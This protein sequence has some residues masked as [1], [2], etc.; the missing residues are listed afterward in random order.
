MRYFLHFCVLCFVFLLCP[1]FLVGFFERNE[2]QNTIIQNQANRKGNKTTRCKQQNHLVL[3]QKQ[4]TL[5][6]KNRI[7]C[8][9]WKQTTLE[10]TQEQKH[11][12]EQIN[13][14]ETNMTKNT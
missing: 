4:T 3:L 1:V 6:Q 10:N 7:D 2:K 13:Y 9:K 8:L 12:T 5:T 14:L 11:E